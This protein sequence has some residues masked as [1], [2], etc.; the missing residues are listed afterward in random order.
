MYCCCSIFHLPRGRN[1]SFRIFA[2]STIHMQA[3]IEMN[4]L[5][6]KS[7][8]NMSSC[9]VQAKI[10]KTWRTKL[11][12]TSVCWNRWPARSVESRVD[13]GQNWLLLCYFIDIEW[14]LCN[15]NEVGSWNVLAKQKIFI[16][17][18]TINI[19]RL[20]FRMFKKGA[21]WDFGFCKIK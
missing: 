13:T 10:A 18:L 12:V 16:I 19:T 17:M 1:S 4:L 6:K 21:V 2:R 14:E 8:R 5:P 20:E 3:V 7:A 15:L 9:H 11:D